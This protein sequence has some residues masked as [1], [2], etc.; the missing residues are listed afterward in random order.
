V[1]RCTT[2]AVYRVYGVIY[3]MW[4]SAASQNLRIW[5]ITGI[6]VPAQTTKMR[7]TQDRESEKRFNMY[8]EAPGFRLGPRVMTCAQA[9][10]DRVVLSIVIPPLATFC[11]R[12][13]RRTNTGA[14]ATR[15]NV[16][17]SKALKRDEA[18]RGESRGL[19]SSTFRLNASIFCGMSWLHDFPPVY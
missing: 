8:K 18:M 10:G 12:L 16:R 2:C 1:C 5:R 17:Q 4:H 15:R 14:D 13:A 7:S 19:H 3:R 11:P 6:Q 9:R